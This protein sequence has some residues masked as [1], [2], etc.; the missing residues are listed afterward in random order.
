MDKK[1]SY[2]GL[3]RGLGDSDDVE[4]LEV[5]GVA[6]EA[7][8]SSAPPDPGPDAGGEDGDGE[9]DEYLLDFDDPEQGTLV[10]GGA[11]PAP[12]EAR[13][14]RGSEDTDSDTD[15]LLRLRADYDNLRKRIDRERREFEIHANCALVGRLLPVV[16]N[17]DRALAAAADSAVEGPLRKGLVL[18]H[19][20]LT[21]QLREEG[22]APIDTVGQ[23]FDPNLHDA[24]ATDNMSD[25]P[26]NTVVEEMQ[27]GYLFQDRVLRPAMVR[28]S[29]GNGETG[30]E[31]AEETG[32]DA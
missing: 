6:E 8:P 25:Q 10:A 28:V 29:T 22:L 14:I 17:L 23:P 11:T 9:S 3:A 27:R 26:P 24:V 18:I 13:P 16:D 2:S 20:Q 1:D 32:E 30:E 7:G 31:T 12:A 4:I 15:R 5:V 19:R 21:E